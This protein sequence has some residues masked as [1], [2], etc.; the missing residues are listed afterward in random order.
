MTAT[1]ERP[2][3]FSG[4]MV[5]PLLAGTKTQ[6]RRAMKHQPGDDTTV[7][8]KR[9]H[10]T[11]IDRHG[12]EQPGPETFGALWDDGE[13]GLPCP[14]GQPGDQLYVREKFSGKRDYDLG[15]EGKKWPPSAWFPTDPLWYWADGNPERG[16]W[17]KP[18][19]AIH[20]PRWA[21]RI[22]LEVTDVRVERLQDIEYNDAEAEGV[23]RLPLQDGDAHP[24]WTADVDK[25]PAL[26]SRSATG[27]YHKLWN[28]IN[29][30]GSWDLNP[31]VWAISFKRVTP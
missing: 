4:A 25:W 8:V 21:S 20:M 14:Y 2:I 31:W 30:A 15:H 27:A 11:I 19:P 22:L 16:D 3:L 6:T 28:R 18:K 9:Y 23:R 7:H 5:R 17:T 29:G 13:S 26:H 12:D 10:P 24:W 1:K